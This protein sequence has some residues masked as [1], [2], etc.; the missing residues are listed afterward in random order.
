MP[1]LDD[2]PSPSGPDQASAGLLVVAFCAAWC[3]TCDEFRITFDRLAAARPL[4]RF[5]WLDIE[6]ETEVVG[7]IDIENFPTIAAYDAGRLVHFGI[8]LPQGALVARLLDSLDG[9]SPTIP[10]DAAVTGL[11]QRLAEAGARAAR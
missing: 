1:T 11:P 5:V 4:D 7:D 2:F 3:N 10:G 6:D 8:S 9:A